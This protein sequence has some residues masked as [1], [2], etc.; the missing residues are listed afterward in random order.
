M[1]EREA[2]IYRTVSVILFPVAI[3]YGVYI[4]FHGHLTPG[5]AFP[6]GV[7][8]AT[9][10]MMKYLSNIDSPIDQSKT[11][12]DAENFLTLMILCLVGTTLVEVFIT[13]GLLGFMPAP[14]FS[15]AQILLLN[16]TGALKVGS[17]MTAIII[18]FFL[19]WSPRKSRSK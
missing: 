17:A 16:L 6:A 5:G 3:L 4:A 19:L 18:A 11:P 1:K 7:V 15:A 13:P 14:L 10:L 9:A 12:E 2:P 8:I